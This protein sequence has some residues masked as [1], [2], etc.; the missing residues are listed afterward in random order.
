MSNIELKITSADVEDCK[1]KLEEESNEN[2]HLVPWEVF[3]VKEMFIIGRYI[4]KWAKDVF[5]A[6]SI[7]RMQRHIVEE[8]ADVW[9]QAVF[10]TKQFI[11]EKGEDK[12]EAIERA[13]YI[14]NNMI[15]EPKDSKKLWLLAFRLGYNYGTQI[16]DDDYD[17]TDRLMYCRCSNDDLWIGRVKS[18]D[19]CYVTLTEAHLLKSDNPVLD[20]KVPS[21]TVYYVMLNNVDEMRP[22]TTTDLKKFQGRYHINHYGSAKPMITQKI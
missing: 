3:T 18:Y 22:L 15:L 14:L 7:K 17:W 9:N 5:V 13:A 19:G 21:K 1:D 16:G 2:P 11:S 6:C 10:W 4:R 12:A 20:G 8:T